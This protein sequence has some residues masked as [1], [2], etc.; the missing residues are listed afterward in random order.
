MGFQRNVSCGSHGGGEAALKNSRE[1]I[2]EMMKSDLKILSEFLGSKNYFFGK[3]PHHLDCVAFA[4]V[5]QFV[6]VPIGDIKTWMETETPNLIAH[7]ERIKAKW[8]PDWE[9]M[10]TSLEL[11]THLPKKELTPEE[12]E[13]QK[14]EE[15]RK[16][17]EAKK[18][19][20]KQKEKVSLSTMLSPFLSLSL[21]LV[22]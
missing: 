1:E 4:N 12:I 15:E 18:K 17:E 16:A 14:K 2:I 22:L 6:Y 3:D 9:E 21:L 20:E 11:N 8:W 7:V 5:A 13:A 10:T 19:E